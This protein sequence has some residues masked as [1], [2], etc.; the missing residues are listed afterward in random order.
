M[1]KA[2][3]KAAVA[4]Y[5]EKPP[6]WGVFAVRCAASGQIWVGGTRNI[7]TH[8]NRL[9]FSLRQGVALPASLIEAWR[10]HGEA[11]LRFEALEQFDPELSAMARED[12]L[13]Q[14]VAAWRQ[15]LDATA[16]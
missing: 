12:A 7:D 14:R 16:I 1:Q 2:D 10:T 8:A 9:F 11:G 13:K 15:E 6:A 5:K 3:R 4:A